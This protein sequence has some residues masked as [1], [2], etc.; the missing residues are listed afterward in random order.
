VGNEVPL[1]V[2]NSFLDRSCWVASIGIWLWIVISSE[3][4]SMDVASD[5]FWINLIIFLAAGLGIVA[6][7]HF[8]ASA[9]PLLLGV[10]VVTAH[11]VKAGWLW[12]NLYVIAATVIG[13]CAAIFKL[14]AYLTIRLS[15]P[16]KR[17]AAEQ[18]ARLA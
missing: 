6:T 1:S 5:A 13:F 16:P 9:L 14:F 11:D 18:P 12:V 17:E 10:M 4:W 8:A 3:I 15:Q 7:T 2:A